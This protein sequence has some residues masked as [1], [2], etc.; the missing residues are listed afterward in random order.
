MKVTLK[1]DFTIGGHVKPAGL[2]IEVTNSYGKKLIDDGIARAYP[3]I[4]EKV[5]K[6]KKKR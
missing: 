3:T 6:N 1:E 5:F 2:V 4:I